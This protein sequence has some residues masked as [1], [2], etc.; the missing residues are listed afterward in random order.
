MAFGRSPAEPDTRTDPRRACFASVSAAS[1]RRR[2]V[3]V[4]AH[5]ELRDPPDTETAPA[6]PIG[7]AASSSRSPRT[8]RRSALRARPDDREA[9][10]AEPEYIVEA[11]RHRPEAVR[12]LEQ[13]A[14]RGDDSDP[15]VQP[16]ETVDV[17]HEQRERI[18]REAGPKKLPLQ[19]IGERLAV[20]EVGEHVELGDDVRVSQVQRARDRRAR[21]VDERREAVDV[22]LAE[23]SRPVSRQ[24]PE[25]ALRLFLG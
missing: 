17:D 4:V 5:L 15:R 6:S 9:A 21:L 22:L 14:V 10:A 18:V 19:H 25:Q 16:R 23:A 7:L 13:D 11:V 3:H 2:R 8:A 24:D 20:E 1:A 12:Q